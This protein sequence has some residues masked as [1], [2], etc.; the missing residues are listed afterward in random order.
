MSKS[1]TAIVKIKGV[2]E[3]VNLDQLKEEHKDK[4]LENLPIDCIKLGEDDLKEFHHKIRQLNWDQLDTFFQKKDEE[5]LINPDEHKFTRMKPDNFL[6]RTYR[7][8]RIKEIKAQEKL[9]KI[10]SKQDNSSKH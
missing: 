1:R 3:Q 8:G 6:V 2:S 4:L 9:K 5:D 10:S 7:I